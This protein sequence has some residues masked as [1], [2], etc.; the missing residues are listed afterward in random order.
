MLRAV[1]AAGAAALLA[2]SVTIGARPQEGAWRM[3]ALSHHTPVEQQTPGGASQ[4]DESLWVTNPTS[5]VW[6]ADDYERFVFSGVLAAGAS[7]S[8]TRCVIGDWIAHLASI[9]SYD[10]GV[11]VSVEFD[12]VAVTGASA[13]CI[14]G[15]DFDY[16]SPTLSLIEGSNGGVGSVMVVTFTVTNTLGRKVQKAGAGAYL[17][18]HDFQPPGC[19]LGSRFGVDP[20]WRIGSS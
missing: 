5:C 6:D 16:G 4:P 11:S 12:S 10:A 19:V 20:A 8:L 3:T 1:V 17:G 18:S 9:V 14:A 15:P 2:V 7:M 13:A